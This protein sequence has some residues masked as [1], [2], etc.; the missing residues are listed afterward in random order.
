LEKKKKERGKKEEKKKT[1]PASLHSSSQSPIKVCCAALRRAGGD[2]CASRHPPKASATQHRTL[3][4]G[5][6]AAP[7]PPERSHLPRAALPLPKLASGPTGLPNRTLAVVLWLY[8]NRTSG[9][10][11]IV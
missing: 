8:L 6:D 5:R 3:R 2:R 10:P 9:F 7:A 1:T 4:N 11:T